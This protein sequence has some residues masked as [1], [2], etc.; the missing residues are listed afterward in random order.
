MELI[1]ISYSPWTEKARWALDHHGLEYRY[2]EH[3]VVLSELSLRLKLGKLGGGDAT[4]PALIDGKTRLVD[5]LRIARYTD[6]RGRGGKLFPD[7]ALAKIEK[8]NASCENALDAA[9]AFYIEGL[10]ADREGLKEAL[11]R[12]VPRALRGAFTPVASFGAARVRSWFSAGSRSL[13]ERGAQLRSAMTEL[14]ASISGARGGFLLGEFTFADIAGAVSVQ[15]VQPVAD[16]YIRLGTAAR[17]LWTRTELAREF[18]DVVEWRDRVYSERRS[19][20]T[21]PPVS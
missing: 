12:F 20:A 3:V 4:V 10:L 17:R 14:R 2:T 19:R 16:R 11:P 1:G 6:E 13:E 18:A 21:L 9:R 15:A 7:G 8:I 5:S